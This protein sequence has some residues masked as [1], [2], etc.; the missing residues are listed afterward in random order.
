MYSLGNQYHKR[1]KNKGLE[2]WGLE[3]WDLNANDTL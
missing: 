3:N 1:V 2:D